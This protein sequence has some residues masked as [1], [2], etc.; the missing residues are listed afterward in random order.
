MKLIVFDLDGTL[1][2]SLPD[3]HNAINYSLRHF[4]LK[5]NT[6]LQTQ[7]YIG[8][9][10]LNL[11]KR[12]ALKMYD[13]RLIL[14]SPLVEVVYEFY[15]DYYS[16]HNLIKTDKYK[17]TLET[18]HELKNRGYKLAVLSNKPDRDTKFIVSRFFENVFDMVLGQTNLPIKPDKAG[19]IEIINKLNIDISE[20]LYIGDSLVDIALARNAGCKILS[21]SYGYTN[22]EVLA[23]AKPDYL[24][25]DFKQIMEVLS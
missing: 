17:N 19:L 1:I 7:K 21:V 15:N 25:D 12:S 22:K 18:L 6:L 16:S 5:P 24:I 11:V 23:L 9:G 13:V 14:T 20:T 2:N 8:N 10:T 4:N 3:I